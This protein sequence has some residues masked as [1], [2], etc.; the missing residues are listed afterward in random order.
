M[1]KALIQ[2][3]SKVRNNLPRLAELKDGP[4][5][6]WIDITLADVI[7]YFHTKYHVMIGMEWRFGS[8]RLSFKGGNHP[9]DCSK[10]LK[11]QSQQMITF[12]NDLI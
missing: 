5:K 10:P 4:K 1:N 3:E 9:W 7:E 12:L 11:G 2:L 8:L 6:D